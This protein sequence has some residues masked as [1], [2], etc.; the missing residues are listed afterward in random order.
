MTGSRIPEGLANLPPD[1]VAGHFDQAVMA[2]VDS[3]GAVRGAPEDGAIGAEGPA[4]AMSPAA[5]TIIHEGVA[6]PRR[7]LPY[8]RKTIAVKLRHDD[9]DYV[10]NFGVDPADGRIVEM[11]LDG[12]G[13]AGPMQAVLDD[14]T[15][16]RVMVDAPAVSDPAKVVLDDAAAIISLA[17]QSG[18]P[19]TAMVSIVGMRIGDPGNGFASIIGAALGEAVKLAREPTLL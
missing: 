14:G 3:E 2:V 13:K 8:R 15:V 12:S 9:I 19:L 5:V 6:T 11:F 7:R 16:R 4:S 10:V 17:L 1:Q 18:V